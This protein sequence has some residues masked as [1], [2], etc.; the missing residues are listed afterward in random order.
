MTETG[1]STTV[2]IATYRRAEF[3]VPS[4]ES[5]LEQTKLP[6]EIIVLDDS[7]DDETERAV[8]DLRSTASLD[9]V[10]LV[11]RHRGDDSSVPQDARNAIVD[12]ADGEILCF[13]DDDTVCPPDW[14]E[15]L[16]DGY[17]SNPDVGG[18]GGPAIKSTTDCEPLVE[19]TKEPDRGIGSR[20][21]TRGSRRSAAPSRSPSSFRS[22]V[23]GPSARARRRRVPAR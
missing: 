22:G 5:L 3:V 16:K 10:S 13:L 11:Y 21:R 17:R 6:D 2:G 14:L 18:V 19:V 23:S 9:A 1:P 12:E 7:P 20:C 4:L 15:S 8:A